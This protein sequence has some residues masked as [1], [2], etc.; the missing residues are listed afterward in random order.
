V[1]GTVVS[2]APICELIS[3]NV[4]VCISKIF[5][6]NQLKSVN[7]RNKRTQFNTCAKRGVEVC[8]GEGRGGRVEGGDE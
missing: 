1:C 3:I 6:K 2:V 8:K 5:N 7:V 4:S